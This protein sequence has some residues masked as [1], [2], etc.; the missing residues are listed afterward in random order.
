MAPILQRR[1]FICHSTVLLCKPSARQGE[2]PK[3]IHHQYKAQA[4]G[5]K[6][7]CPTN[8]TGRL[9]GKCLQTTT[10][11]NRPDLSRNK[12]KAEEKHQ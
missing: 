2:I 7:C 9:D 3:H 5:E 6:N 10:M 1:S 12:R 11:L 4:T 8:G